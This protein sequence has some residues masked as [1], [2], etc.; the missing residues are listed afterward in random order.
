MPRGQLRTHILTLLRRAHQHRR[1][2]SAA[3]DRALPASLSRIS[4]LRDIVD[5]GDVE[6]AD[7]AVRLKPSCSCQI[8]LS[9]TAS[10][11]L[12]CA[13]RVVDSVVS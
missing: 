12:I 2:R 1:L 8:S 11:S 5:F 13:L 9:I 7:V 4:G 6:I 10:R 3:K